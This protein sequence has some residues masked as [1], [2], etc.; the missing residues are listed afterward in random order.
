[1]VSPDSHLLDV[2]DLGVGLESELGQGTVVIQTGHG[3]ETGGGEI[4]GVSLADQSV[5]VGGVANDDGLDITGR[6]VVDGLA[7]I[8]EDLTVVLEEIGTLHAWSTGLGTDEEVV[9]DILEGN[10][11]VARNNDIVEEGEGAIV[12]LSLDSLEDLLLEGEVEK[13]EDDTLVLA[14]EFTAIFTD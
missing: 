9:V 7:N 1:M 10:G 5:G 13:V 6:V 8:D 14:E 2:G 12:Q 3:R 4:W 11:E